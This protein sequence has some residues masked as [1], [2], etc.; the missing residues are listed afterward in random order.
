[1]AIAKPEQ[2]DPVLGRG[3][4]EEAS[5]VVDG[6]SVAYVT[7]SEYVA[8]VTDVGFA[9][10]EGEILGVIGESG[11]GKSTLGRAV[12]GLLPR[13]AHIAAGE[14][15]LRLGGEMVSITDST[16]SRHLHGR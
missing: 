14:I 3:K 5:L 15:R 2:S 10:Y 13:T 7:K 12:L 6:L 11:S 1:M 4:V 8:A 9:L 16:S